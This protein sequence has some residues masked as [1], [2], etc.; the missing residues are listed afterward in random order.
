[1]NKAGISQAILAEKYLKGDE[2]SVD[3]LFHR[4]AK[5]IAQAEKTPAGIEKWTTEFVSMMYSGAIGAGRIMS[6]A[7]TNIKATLINCFAGSTV[8][9][10]EDG[11]FPIKELAGLT[12]TVNSIDGKRLAEFRSFGHQKLWNVYFQN[13]Q[14]EQATQGHEWVVLKQKSG[15]K[16]SILSNV[17][18]VTTDQLA[19]RAVPVVPY[20]SRPAKNEDYYKGIA[21]G[22][23]FG[24][25]SKISNVKGNRFYMYLFGNKR[26][27]IDYVSPFTDTVTPYDGFNKASLKA[28]GICVDGENLKEVPVGKSTSYLY[29]FI[30]GLIA[31]DGNVCEGNTTIFQSNHSDI[32]S[33]YNIL[34]VI[35]MAANEPTIY[36]E[37]SPY[38][39]EYAPS[40]VIRIKALSVCEDDI[41]RFDHRNKLNMN[42]KRAQREYVIR[43]EET[44]IVEEVYCAV[45]EVTRTFTIAGNI[46]TGNC[47]VQP[48]GDC[49]QGSDSDGYPGIYEALKEAAETM[50]RG[51]GVG[52]DFSRIRPKG[53]FVKGTHSEASGP[54]SYM[55]VFDSSCATVESAG[56]RRGAQMGVLRIDHPDVL[57]FILAKRSAGR[58]KNFNVS[59]FI[60]NDFFKVLEEKGMWELVH[61]AQPCDRFLKENPQAYQRDDGKWV[62]RVISAVDMWDAVMRSNYD[63]A[64]PGV[65]LSSNISGQNNLWYAEK[66]EA[67][68]PCA[69]Q[70]LP[71][72]GCCDLGQ[73]IL[74]KFVKKPFTKEAYF[75]WEGFSSVAATLVRF[76]DN[77]LEVTHWPLPQQKVEAMN[78][79]RIGAGYTGLGSSLVML[80]M[81]YGSDEGNAFAEK[82]SEELRNA[83]YRAS[84][85]LAKER[86]P[87]PLLD[88]E[89]HLQSEFCKRLPQDIRDGIKEH[90]IR[91]SHLLSIAPTG[92]VSLA[93]A[94]NCSNGIEPLFS[95][96][97]MRNKRT[98]DNQQETFAV[99]DH[100]LS[101][102][103][104]EGDVSEFVDTTKAKEFKD[105]LLVA[106]CSYSA[107]FTFEGKQFSVDKVL[108]ESFVTAQTLTV[109]QHLSVLAKVQPYIDAAISKTI[110]VPTDY[111]FED[112]KTIYVTA[113]KLGL[114]GVACYRPNDVRG[115]VLVAGPTPKAEET[116]KEENT[117]VDDIDPAKATLDNRPK[118]DLEAVVKKVAYSGPNGD[119]SMYLTVSFDE[120]DGR[121]KGEPITIIR[122][123]EVFITASPDGVPS[124]WV[125][126]YARNLSLLARSGVHLLAKALQHGREIRSDKGRVRYG[127][128]TKADG[129][130]VPRFHGSEV[131]LIAYAVQEVLVSKGVLDEEG[132]VVKNQKP[133]QPKAEKV[134]EAN[135]VSSNNKMMSG[136]ECKECGAHAVIKKD[137]CDF[138]TN[139]G[140][141]GSCG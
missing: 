68:N 69:E 112:F 113:N 37:N 139:C 23:V 75:D 5:G 82:V 83:A 105:A 4:V 123:M 18:K 100:A 59:L 20:I 10:T 7:G 21:H 73:V 6:A 12:K 129:T 15:T 85:E 125:A 25:G 19:G 101:V 140:S 72:Y 57:D 141:T 89:K 43:V 103:I 90:G 33:I 102:F 107:Q 91:N 13:G 46:L 116:K 41:L 121:V 86:G 126:A 47:F 26:E 99:M 138:C 53:A 135:N 80:G 133:I 48:V 11:P 81:K 35:G 36:R 115:A 94:N 132:N 92:T 118:G 8:V 34:K 22:M 9:L 65:L 108:P 124:E 2:S 24:D 128:F 64:E 17:E 60:E 122:P 27:L 104:D 93:F 3:E 137:G 62:Y 98:S 54:C 131:A 84:I 56:Y 45:E 66:L 106:I 44:D 67:T 127:Y 114:K 111:S 38:T 96:A 97:Y 30:C 79:R 130:R 70:C 119:A 28:Y 1:M 88:I 120:V 87:F 42:E 61:K 136:K 16:S 51:G 50:R 58:W 76:L 134:I 52:Y 63:F 32:V 117:Q 49:I 40:Y 14:V 71:A 31:T 95:L 109:D 77:V 39:G 78:K 55:D 110:N 74:T 29:G